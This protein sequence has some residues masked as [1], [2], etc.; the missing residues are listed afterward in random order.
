MPANEKAKK[1]SSKKKEEVKQEIKQE[2]IPQGNW[3]KIKFILLEDDWS[4]ADHEIYVEA[5]QN[6]LF[7][8]RQLIQFHGKIKN[9]FVYF[10]K[11]KQQ[12]LQLDFNTKIEDVL[13]DKGAPTKQ[14][15]KT[16]QLYYSFDVDLQTHLL[17]YDNFTVLK[18][19]D[20][21]KNLQ[22]KFSY[23]DKNNIQLNPN[24][25]KQ[26]KERIQ[27]QKIIPNNKGTQEHH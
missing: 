6:T 14:Q 17:N 13:Q 22:T 7:L 21:P 11:H 26:E 16:H 2:E 8:Q 19:L 24:I 20:K 4:F 23:I 9:I 15:A 3:I 5:H 18:H 10:D 25:L 12:S 27:A 1:K